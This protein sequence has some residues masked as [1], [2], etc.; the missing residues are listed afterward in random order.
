MVSFHA[1]CTGSHTLR[2]FGGRQLLVP[3]GSYPS[4]QDTG[5]IVLEWRL[6]KD[7]MASEALHGR[8]GYC[9]LE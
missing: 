1:F 8:A 6:W 5:G 4:P 3:G 7:L 2:F 9:R